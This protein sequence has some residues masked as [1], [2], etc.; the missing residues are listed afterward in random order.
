MTRPNYIL[1]K[2]V[3]LQSRSRPLRFIIA[4][5]VN[6][7]FGFLVYSVTIYLFSRVWLGLVAGICAG[8]IFNF[9]TTGGFVFRDTSRQRIPRFFACYLLIYG[10]NFALLE[11]TMP[12][13]HGPIVAQAL[14]TPII[15]L[16][17]YL[18]LTRFVFLGLPPPSASPR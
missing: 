7:I 13:L 4:G 11:L 18:L 10:L 16:F 2:A 1:D 5:V 17:S 3:T 12:L 14:L 8:I 15:A 6:S 9:F